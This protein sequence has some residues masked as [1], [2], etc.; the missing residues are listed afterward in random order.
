VLTQATERPIDMRRAEEP[1][2]ATVVVIAG[3]N[4]LADRLSGLLSR[5]GYRVR[6]KVDTRA[7][8]ELNFSVEAEAPDLVILDAGLASP[9]SLALCRVLRERWSGPLLLVSD[10][11]EGID[12]VSSFEAGADDYLPRYERDRELL[13]RVRTL[14]RR[15]SKPEPSAPDEVRSVGDVTLDP[16]RH[17]VWVGGTEVVLSRK[18]FALL[19]LLMSNPGRVLVRSRLMSEVWGFH[20]D[21]SHKT[22]E[23]HIGRLR[24]KI[25]DDPAHPTRILTVRGIGYRYQAS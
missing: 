25:E 14:L 16:D 1:T 21:P 8:R 7:L 11:P 18:E 20:L 15:R 3:S 23:V 12:P 4:D 6:V 5:E 10:L 2:L 9:S 22:L 13:A 19:E 17:Q 24:A